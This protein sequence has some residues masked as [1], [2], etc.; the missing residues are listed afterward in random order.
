[1]AGFALILTFFLREYSLDSK[2]VRGD[3]AKTPGDLESGVVPIDG[4]LHAPRHMDGVDLTPT[5]TIVY[6]EEEEHQHQ[7]Y[8]QPVTNGEDGRYNVANEHQ[9]W[10]GTRA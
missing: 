7:H 4:D 10:H 6:P 8:Q 9:G 5:N 2:V 1:M 3:G